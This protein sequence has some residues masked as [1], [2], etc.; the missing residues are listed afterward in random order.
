MTTVHDILK[1]IESIAPPYMKESW[2]NVGLLCGRRSREVK[3]ILVALD[4]FRNVIEE[5]IAEKYPDEFTPMPP[6]SRRA[7]SGGNTLTQ[8]DVPIHRTTESTVRT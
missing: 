1:Y 3:K 2:D 7:S 4:P 8:S 5:A 6:P